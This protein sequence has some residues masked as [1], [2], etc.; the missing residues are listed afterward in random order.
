M[1]DQLEETVLEDEDNLA[2]TDVATGEATSS[3]IGNAGSTL[4]G[5]AADGGRRGGLPVPATTP[6]EVRLINELKGLIGE[7]QGGGAEVQAEAEAAHV[8]A[9]KRKE[10]ADAAAEKGESR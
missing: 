5:G 3:A 8:D 10:E 1:A 9:R 6:S 7:V 2:G 4:E